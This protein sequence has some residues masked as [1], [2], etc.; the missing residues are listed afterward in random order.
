M[1]NPLDRARF[2]AACC[3]VVATI[4]AGLEARASSTWHGAARPE[5]EGRS[6]SCLVI[7]TADRAELVRL[8][9]SWFVDS[10][11]VNYRQRTGSP[12]L[13]ATSIDPSPSPITDCQL[14]NERYRVARSAKWPGTPPLPV[15]LVK[16]GSW[17]Y[18]GDARILEENGRIHQIVVFDSLLNVRRIE[19]LLM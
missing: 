15:A 12:L 16:L 11:G 6:D 9:R 18:L 13:P 19:R 14:A 8:A 1:S 17:G 10:A 7:S 3:L 4:G 5:T 2:A